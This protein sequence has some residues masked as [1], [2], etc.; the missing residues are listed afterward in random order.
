MRKEVNVTGRNE[1]SQNTFGVAIRPLRE[2]VE[3]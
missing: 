1:D 2:K 3:L